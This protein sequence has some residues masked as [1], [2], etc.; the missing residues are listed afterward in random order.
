MPA[1][2]KILGHE[3]P[4]ANTWTVLYTAP[5][6]AG[7]C[8]ISNTIIAANLL[9]TDTKLDVQCR[10]VGEASDINKQ[11]VYKNIA[12]FGNNSWVQTLAITLGPGESIWVRTP[13]SLA[14]T[15]FGEETT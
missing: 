15:A 3:A 9:T 13:G 7:K 8:A 12:V 2:L 5:V 14:I 1:E 11:Y 6:G 4:A 10:K